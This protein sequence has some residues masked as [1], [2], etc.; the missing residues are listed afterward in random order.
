MMLVCHVY[1][2]QSVCLHVKAQLIILLKRSLIQIM[3]WKAQKKNNQHEDAVHRGKNKKASWG[4]GKYLL[5]VP[6]PPP[7]PLGGPGHASYF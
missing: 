6:P 3:Q 1:M 5:A 7:Q 4:P 2:H